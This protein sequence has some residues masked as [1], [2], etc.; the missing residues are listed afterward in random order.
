MVNQSEYELISATIDIKLSEGVKAI[1]K[2]LLN[3]SIT[4]DNFMSWDFIFI[5]RLEGEIHYTMW[6]IG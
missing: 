2:V 6:G 5:P 3:S 1:E 4:R